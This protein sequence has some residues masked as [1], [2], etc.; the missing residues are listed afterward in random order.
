MW[1][2][3]RADRSANQSERRSRARGNGRREPLPPIPAAPGLPA[4]MPWNGPGHP[5]NEAGGGGALARVQAASTGRYHSPNQRHP[6]SVGTSN[7]QDSRGRGLWLP[8]KLK[9]STENPVT[10]GLPDS[11][12]GS[13]SAARQSHWP[14]LMHVHS[15]QRIN[16]RL[17]PANGM[18][19]SGNAWPQARGAIDAS[20]QTNRWLPWGPTL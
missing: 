6:H 2:R 20:A 11:P 10:G 13:C 5:A 18:A 7:G 12:W 17:A 16:N 14:L 9:D 19:M 15:L 8:C 4:A 3:Q 1:A